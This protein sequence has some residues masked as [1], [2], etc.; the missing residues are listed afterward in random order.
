MGK[1]GVLPLPEFK[2][3]NVATHVLSHSISADG[4]TDIQTANV[5][6]P[7]SGPSS[8]ASRRKLTQQP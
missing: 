1:T 5:A 7:T 8:S 2:Q 3:P 6:T 4:N